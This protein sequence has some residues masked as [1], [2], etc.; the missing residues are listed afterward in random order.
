MRRVTLKKKL[1]RM[2]VILL[3]TVALILIALLVSVSVGLSNR[4]LATIEQH[5]RVT[6]LTK[7]GMLADNHGT[8]LKGLVLDNAFGD[9]Q[10]LIERTVTDDRDIVYGLFTN[11]AGRV[12]AFAG[13]GGLH[14]RPDPKAPQ[15]LGLTEGTQGVKARATREVEL[16]GENVV[17]IAAPVLD[18]TEQ[19]GTI[20][21]GL[22]TRRMHE[23]LRQARAESQRNIV[24][25][26][27][28]SLGV[29]LACAFAAA[30]M[31]RRQAERVAKP[32][33]DLA[34]AARALAGG[35]RDV[36]V[37]IQSNDE[38]QDLGEA[39][40]QMVADLKTSYDSLEDLNR[41]LE[42]KVEA[43]TLELA[44]RNRDMR[45]V[46]DNV[47]E[48]F[49]TLSA[50]GIMAMEHS[51]ILDRWFGPYG[52]RTSFSKYIEGTNAAFSA[53][54]DLGWEALMEGFLPLDLCIDQLPRK[55][56]AHGSTWQVRYTPI[57]SSGK[58]EG[59]LVVVQDVTAE[60]ARRREEQEQRGI[61]NAFQRLMR[62]RAGFLA[63]YRETG[64]L[65]QQTVERVHERDM[66]VLKRVIHTV[67]GNT[68]MF[69]IEHVA[70]LCH[71]LEND[72]AE[73]GEPPPIAALEELSR[74]WNVIAE[75]VARVTE[76]ADTN[77]E[78]PREDLQ[79]LA[80]SLRTIPAARHL[81]NVVDSWK[82]EPVQVPLKRLAEQAVALARRLGKGDLQ[83][84]VQAE[85]IRC[86][87]KRWAPFWS[88]LVHVLRN[89]VDHGIETP[90][91]RE[92]AGK[93]RPSIAFKAQWD[94]QDFVISGLRRRQGSGLR[95]HSRE[96]R[97]DAPTARDPRGPHQ[98]SVRRRSQYERRGLRVLWARRR[99]ECRQTP[100][101]SHGRTCSDRLR[102][103]TRDGGEL[104]I[105]AA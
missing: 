25:S 1:V 20:R 40:N 68:S 2:M 43:R 84:S 91:E 53:Y 64:A 60:L 14:D 92:R 28:V 62:D 4:N 102:G 55:I 9:I 45:L 37:D 74:A 71:Q 34:A 105:P 75:N 36:R 61:M 46:L 48:G 100:G 33:T 95:P 13:P 52:E 27:A 38:V 32:V 104:P 29:A 103:R 24:E 12:L 23:A 47:E 16:F 57:M 83:V 77:L 10:Q 42:K 35:R 44:G 94:N 41:N 93:G 65:V 98:R 101:R 82:R 89:A 70:A 81:A 15:R 59:L 49:L 6:L 67:K 90:E 22:S 11:D 8:A 79:S 78:V 88:D 26:L 69:G 51:S 66:V 54:F 39:F 18:G 72:I 7:A 86:D 96:G 3:A 50:A 56:E 17:E 97:A 73:S 19:L 21:Y 87:V 63:F 99:H 30:L 58:L 5:H 31:S 76:G 85:M 80:A